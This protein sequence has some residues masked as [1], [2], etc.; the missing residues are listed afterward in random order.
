VLALLLLWSSTANLRAQAAA[1]D[2]VGQGVPGLKRLSIE[3][4]AR[5]SVLS[6]SRHI[7][8]VSDAAAS[9]TVITGDS[10]RRA[11]VRTL[12][13]ALR[14]ATGVAVG[15][16]GPSWSISARGFNS[17]GANKMVVLLDGRSLYTPLFSGVFWNVPD[18]LLA[19]VDRIEVVRGAGGTLWGANAMNGVINIITKLASETQGALVQAGVGTA[20]NLL[21][22][23]YGGRLGAGAYRAYAKFRH[24]GALPLVSGEDSREPMRAGQAGFRLDVDPAAAQAFTL[25]G[26]VYRGTVD[27]ALGAG[28]ATIAFDGG[29][30]L[31]RMRRTFRSGAQLQLQAYYDN[32]HRRV[33]TQYA[34]RRHTG[35]VELQY[36]FSAGTR[37]DIV[38]GAGLTLSRDRTRR[39]G[40]FFFEP[41]A[42]TF[43]LLNVFV[44]DDIEI[45]PGRLSA[46]VG[47]KFEHNT[48]TGFEVQ[49]T[50]RVRWRPARSHTIWGAVSRAVR[51]PTRFDTD[52]RFTA[53]TPAVVLRGDDDFRSET[54][55]G[56]E[57]GYRTF[58]APH[59]AVA[60]AAFHNRYDD[61]RS[62]EPTPPQGVP[63]VLA[64]KHEGQ[65]SGVEITGRVDL[66]PASSVSGGYAFLRGR[67]AFD[68]DS[69]DP[70]GG[71]LEHNDPR[72]QLWVRSSSDL[73]GG[74]ELDGR[75]RW[76]G[77]LPNPAVPGYAELTLRA[78]R[79]VGDRFLVEVVGDN[80]LHERHA[81]WFNLGPRVAVP[82]S[83]FA[84]LTWQSR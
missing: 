2:Q 39:T 17:A 65:T 22:A 1:G 14:L 78:A 75:L 48:Y 46:I 57:I 61:L 80:L 68:P 59:A 50:A 25:Q 19:D 8:P 52:L 53:N 58:L 49:P 64:N 79:P 28:M 82:R 35:D 77:A 55:V 63:I 7:E 34:E 81:E 6:S 36:R 16:A 43:T 54:M 30:V 3:E 45:V 26:D 33:P 44:Q 66:G 62:Q 27:L 15:R 67:F 11:G 71:A 23:R 4:L 69:A 31:A 32:T 84:R 24:L 42:R 9:V 83:V 41:A 74:V 70:S 60:V 37:H 76:I 5:I 12:P 21:T 20:E 56:A 40:S 51:M 73:P 72:H 38:S 47:S 29:N 13:E 18:V 10:I